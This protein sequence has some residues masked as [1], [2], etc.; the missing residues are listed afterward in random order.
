MR[1]TRITC[2]G[3]MAGL[4]KRTY[5]E[6]TLAVTLRGVARAIMRVDFPIG[7]GKL[8]VMLQR[9][10][11]SRASANTV[12]GTTSRMTAKAARLIVT[13]SLITSTTL[14]PRPVVPRLEPLPHERLARHRLTPRMRA[15]MV[16]DVPL[17][18]RHADDLLD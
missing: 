1:S 7:D 16:R 2:A 9:A 12:T 15:T 18:I 17:V 10:A 11:A 14:R 4:R 5:W 6:S 3:A 13:S 8:M